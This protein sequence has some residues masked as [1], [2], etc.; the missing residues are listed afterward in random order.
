M[1]D[2]RQTLIDYRLQKSLDTLDE[3]E[4]LIFNQMYS[5]AVNRLYYACFYSV[6]ALLM[7]IELYSKTHKGVIKLFNENFIKTTKIPKEYGLFYNQLFNSRMENDYS[8]FVEIESEVVIDWLNKSKD[9][10]NTII[11]LIK[12]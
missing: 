7:D 4:I 3:A 8:D 2:K 11:E 12:S 10:I 9:F 1:N 6:L 5:G